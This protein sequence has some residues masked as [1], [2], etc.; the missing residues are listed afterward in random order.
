MSQYKAG[1]LNRWLRI[2]MKLQH[3]LYVTFALPAQ[4]V[5]PLIPSVLSLSVNGTNTAFIS[6]VVLRSR[7]VHLAALP[8]PRFS[9]DQINVRTY[10]RDPL[11]GNPSVYFLR[12]AVNSGSISLMTRIFGLQWENRKIIRSTYEND[13]S[14]EQIELKGNWEG[15]FIIEA[16]PQITRV[17]NLPLFSDVEEGI[18]FLV[19]P[20]TGLYGKSG[21]VKRFNIWHPPVEP[22]QALIKKFQFP[23]LTGL[24]LID[25][26]SE[27][28]AHSVMF[29]PQAYFTIFMPSHKVKEQDNLTED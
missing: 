4:R 2:E 17:S 29:V 23:I 15:N 16:E 22:K 1:I 14:L 7:A 13:T 26:G 21:S 3:V 25:P 5:R 20:L 18:D 24:D 10:V 12:S 9:Y 27:N 8:F 11:S 6:V 28:S 19:R